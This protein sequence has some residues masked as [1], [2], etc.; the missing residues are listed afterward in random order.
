MVG[1][2]G[3]APVGAVRHKV[4]CTV[5]H[6]MKNRTQETLKLQALREQLDG[7]GD[8]AFIAH[9]TGYNISYVRK[10]LSGQRSNNQIQQAAQA[11]IKAKNGVAKRL[12]NMRAEQNI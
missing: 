11:L 10:V 3:E 12:Q 6:K 4:T 2:K 8:M 9:H 7:K 1:V 5:S